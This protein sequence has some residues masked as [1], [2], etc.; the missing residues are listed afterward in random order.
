MKKST[1]KPQELNALKARAKTMAPEALAERTVVRD[2]KYFFRVLRRTARARAGMLDIDAG[3]SDAA[4]STEVVERVLIPPDEFDY[5]PKLSAADKK[6]AKP[7]D[8]RL[9]KHS[10][11]FAKDRGLLESDATTGGEGDAAELP[12]SVDHRGA[13]SPVKDQGGR[14]TCVSHAC[15][16]LLESYPHI[17]DDLSEQYTHFKFNI[18]ENHAQNTDK[19]L[20][21]TDGAVYL[22]RNDGRVCLESQWPYIS[23]QSTIDQQVAQG[24]YAPP[25]GA[26]NNQKFGM[27]NYKIIGDDGLTG[28]SIKNTRYLEALLFQGYNIVVG[29]H[30]SWDDSDN[31]EILD[32]VLDA[33]G[34]IPEGT[35]GHAMLIVGYNRTN[36][37]F[38][39]KNSW[40]PTWGHNGYGYFHY[41]FLRAC[42]KYGFVVDSVVPA[43]PA[44]ALPRKLVRAPFGTA[45]LSRASLRAAVLFCKTSSGRYAVV[46]AYAGDNLLLRNLQIFNPNGSVHL[47][48]DSVIV[49][50]SYLCDLDTGS[51]TANS[52]D[53]WWE[54]VR[55]GVHFLVPRNGATACIGYNLANLTHGA[56]RQLN[57][58][59]APVAS[60]DLRY[61]V[62]AGVSTTGKTF[63]ILAHA[64]EDN[65]LLLSYI[66]VFK[67]DGTRYRYGQSISVPS[68][69]PFDVDNLQTSNG[70]AADLWWHVISSHVGYLEK[71]STAKMRLVWNL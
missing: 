34:N 13:Q 41:N 71:Y 16:G 43:A 59:N 19:G 32:P 18:F 53:F 7:I 55:P 69:W 26:T 38:I 27:G 11:Y 23:N 50:S 25:S 12:A 47:K 3:T 24:T 20:R 63:K 39:L 57:M 8:K 51:E 52:A 46:E 4:E 2:K 33:N 65:S 28:E 5:I 49:R 21:T 61:A 54:G 14:G 15:M 10:A 30:A 66:E 56:I 40:A 60:A 48:K 9:A 6:A 64:R 35:G 68:S 42:A 36:Q 67:S 22:A 29:V 31:N 1:L 37:Y 45:R 62:I 70:S 58:N 44:L 17:E